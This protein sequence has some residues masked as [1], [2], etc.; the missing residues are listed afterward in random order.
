MV[1][2]CG[3]FD[4]VQLRSIVGGVEELS[5]MAIGVYCEY[6]F[7]VKCALLDRIVFIDAP[8]YV[9]RTHGGSWSESNLER[10]KHLLA[11]EQLVLRCAEVLRHPAFAEDYS[12]NLLKMCEM[13]L[14]TFAH[15]CGR[16]EFIRKNF[17]MFAAV[18]ALSMHEKESSH[19]WKLFL[20]QGG[21][22]SFRV[23]L[24]FIRIKIFCY[25]LILFHLASNF[26]KSLK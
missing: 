7:L 17:G 22:D 26:F 11:G 12:S 13:H 1:S 6:L 9:F 3:L 18:R 4:T 14:I 16:L 5:D 25:Y 20:D 21:T 23:K 24:R 8:Y 10:E 2:T 15:K 19:I